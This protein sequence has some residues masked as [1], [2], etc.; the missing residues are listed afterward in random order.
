MNSNRNW[1]RDEYVYAQHQKGRT[2]KD[3]GQ[4]LGISM[5]RVRQLYIR[6]C[7]ERRQKYFKMHPEARKEWLENPKD[8]KWNSLLDE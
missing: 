8:E 7:R 1:Q 6:A 2:Y 3:I 5:E 4:E